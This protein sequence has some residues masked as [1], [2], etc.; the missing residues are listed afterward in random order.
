MSDYVVAEEYTLPSLGKVYSENVNPVVKIKSMTTNQEMKR[1][2][3]S[4]RAYKTICEIIDECLVENPGISSYDMCLADYQFLLHKLRVVTYGKDYKLEFTCPFCGSKEEATIDLDS[5]E[6]RNADDIDYGD[7]QEFVL[8]KTKKKIRIKMQTPRMID[9]ISIQS[10]DLDKKSKGT[11]G[12]TAFLF[13]LEYMIESVDG[14]EIDSVRKEK[15]V[16]NLPM[17]DTNYIMKKAEKLVES[18]GIQ[19]SIDKECPICGLDY[20]GS[21]RFTQEFFRP[22]ID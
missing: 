20:T 14:E 17:M 3:P 11:Q 1:L 8:P 13:T 6:V 22:S 4:E 19:T 7:L 16:R 5:L 2:A 18:F 15:F 12:D 9:Q 10:K 21:F